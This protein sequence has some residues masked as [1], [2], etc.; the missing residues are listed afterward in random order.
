[1]NS[2]DIYLILD[3]WEFNPREI[4]VRK[5]YGDDGNVKLQLRLDLGLLQMVLD[6]RPD[7]THPYGYES[8]LE[9]YKTKLREYIQENGTDEGFILDTNDC[10]ALQREIMQYYHRYLCFF[11]LK[12]YVNVQRDTSRN[13]EVMDLIKRYASNRND[14]NLVEQYRPY[15]IMMLTRAR[16]NL[17]LTEKKYNQALA[18]IGQG[19]QKIEEFFFEYEQTQ[20][21][22][23]SP[24]L[25]FLKVWFQEVEA[26]RPLTLTE[27]LE[28]EMEWAIAREEY[29]QA[30]IIRDKLNDLLRK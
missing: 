27:Q 2:K 14:I 13:L 3:G 9:Y 26:E 24:E 22:E 17:F 29:E 19:I 1:M 25:K 28:K 12:D 6:G 11:Q 16:A 30:A 8:L 21:V 18:E 20:Q 23:Y 7:G 10:A 5:I 15:V 4:T